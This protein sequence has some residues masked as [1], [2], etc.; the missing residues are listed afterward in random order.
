LPRA[1]AF[2]AISNEITDGDV[3]LDDQ[4]RAPSAVGAT[5][6]SPTPTR[7]DVRPSQA[8]VGPSILPLPIPTTIFLVGVVVDQRPSRE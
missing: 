6:E 2:V 3:V 7:R 4:G 1:I 8:R 5:P